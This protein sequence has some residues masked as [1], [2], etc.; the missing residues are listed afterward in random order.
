VNDQVEKWNVEAAFEEMCRD[1]DLTFEYSDDKTVY[2]RG[3][4]EKEAILAY[5]RTMDRKKAVEI[6]NKCVDEK[7]LPGARMCWHWR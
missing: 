7:M 1:H 2:R 6:W 3:R 4:A 5:A